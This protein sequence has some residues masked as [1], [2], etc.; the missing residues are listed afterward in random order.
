MRR[1]ADGRMGATTKQ[2][3]YTTARPSALSVALE[4]FLVRKLLLEK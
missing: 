1:F 4:R 3:L 2:L